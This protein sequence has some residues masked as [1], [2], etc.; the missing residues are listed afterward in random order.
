VGDD[1]QEA[2]V[3]MESV[4]RTLDVGPIDAKAA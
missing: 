4:F 2:L 1:E 3:A